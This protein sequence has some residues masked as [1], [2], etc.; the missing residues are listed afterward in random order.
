MLRVATTNVQ[1]QT[2]H[3]KQVPDGRE[4]IRYRKLHAFRQARLAMS[5]Y[6]QPATERFLDRS[7]VSDPTPSCMALLI[8]VESYMTAC[9]LANSMV[10]GACAGGE[11]NSRTGF[12]VWSARR[13][14]KF[15]SAGRAVEPL[16][17]PKYSRRRQAAALKQKHVNSR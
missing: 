15:R 13:L 6:C 8:S 7:I 1:E 10:Q 5:S 11:G 3:V 2:S 14:T 4:L 16:A 9:T 12:R 17:R